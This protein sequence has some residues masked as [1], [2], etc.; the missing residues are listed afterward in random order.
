MTEQN[1]TEDLFT[2][3]APTTPTSTVASSPTSVAAAPQATFG[4]QLRA[5]REASGRSLADCGRDLHLPIKVLERL[6]ADL[7]GAPADFVFLRGALKGYAKYLGLPANAC[8]AVLRS[9]APAAQPQLVSVARTSNTRWLLQRY[10][11]AATYIILTATIAVPL[12]LLGLRGGLHRPTAQIVSL[13]QA[14]SAPSAIKRSK[15]VLTPHV[16]A[17]TVTPDAA[18]FRASIAPFSAIGLDDNVASGDTAIDTTAAAPI[19]VG[20][21]PHT[22]TVTATADC[23]Y[24]ITDANGNKVGSGMLHAG[25]VRSWHSAGVLHVTLGNTGGVSV[26]QDGKPLALDGIAHSNVARFDVFGQAGS[27][28]DD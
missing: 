17:P 12:V 4:Q 2:Q 25:D 18:P 26:T 28:A 8:D 5:A 10:G 3:P 11:T 16:P 23:W 6:E 9:V 21:G 14:V 7:A 22:L 27:S 1:N 20:A 15:P 19:V 13:D 24:S